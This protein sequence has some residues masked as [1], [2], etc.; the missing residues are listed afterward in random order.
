MKSSPGRV[1]YTSYCLLAGSVRWLTAPPKQ[2]FEPQ[3]PP[4]EFMDVKKLRKL[5]VTAEHAVAGI[6]R[7]LLMATRGYELLLGGSVRVVRG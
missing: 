2:T 4:V 6:P 3:N 7:Q 1:A 5:Q